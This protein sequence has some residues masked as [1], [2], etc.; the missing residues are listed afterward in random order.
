MFCHV[1]IVTLA[2]KIIWFLN[3]DYFAF[4]TEFGWLAILNEYWVHWQSPKKPSK[5]LFFF[6][7]TETSF[8]VSRFFFC[9][10]RNSVPFLLVS[11]RNIR[12]KIQNNTKLKNFFFSYN[13]HASN[14]KT[15]IHRTYSTDLLAS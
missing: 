3:I 4:K 6:E 7:E 12:H 13:L 8:A 14:L 9:S 5:T 1:E 2:A 15:E 11:I 10:I